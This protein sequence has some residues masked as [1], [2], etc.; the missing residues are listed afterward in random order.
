M[1]AK[2]LLIRFPSSALAGLPAAQE[3]DPALHTDV[4]M[5]LDAP[6]LLLIVL[7][8]CHCLTTLFFKDHSVQYC[9]QII[10]PQSWHLCLC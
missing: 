7:D 6:R 10:L 5:L 3:W 9:D 4:L 2:N 8:F 1:L